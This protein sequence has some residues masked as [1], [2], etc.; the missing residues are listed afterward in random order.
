MY[1]VTFG[2]K[3]SYRDWNLIP[4]SRPVISPPTPKTLYVDIPE[5]DGKLDL[6]ESLSGEIKFD[7]RTITFEFNVREAR[8]RWTDLYSEILNY[9][10]GKRMN[11]YLD[12]DPKYY[13]S[14]RLQ[15]DE[16]RSDKKTSTLVITADVDPYKY[17]INGSLD[18][19][20]WDSF[21]FETDVIREYADIS[22]NG[23]RTFT[24]CG[25]RRSVVPLFI[26]NSADDTGMQVVFQGN[27]FDLL[28][29]TNRVPNIVIKEGESEVTFIGNGTVSID[30]REGSL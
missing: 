14:G 21:N 16:W 1:G 12:E 19:W 20:E 17:N 23:S 29:G 26:V 11:I 18:P 15:V 30:Y 3:H 24:I 5:S 22:V 8:S 9:L 6:S 4:K 2:E 13:Y 10:H 7:N 27:T 28:E 25:S